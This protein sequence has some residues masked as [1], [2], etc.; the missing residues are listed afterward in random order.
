MAELLV[1]RKKSVANPQLHFKPG[2]VLISRSVLRVKKDGV[3]IK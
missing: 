1:L 3:S 2:W